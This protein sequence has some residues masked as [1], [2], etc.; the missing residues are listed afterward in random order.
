MTEPMN[1]VTPT[2]RWAELDALGDKHVRW[3]LTLDEVH[4]I[5]EYLMYDVG[6]VRALT[7]AN[8]L[9]MKMGT[10]ARRFEVRRM[11]EAGEIQSD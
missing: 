5:V 6:T 9:N 7:L 1:A 4:E 3:P 2:T 11:I 10:S 8:R